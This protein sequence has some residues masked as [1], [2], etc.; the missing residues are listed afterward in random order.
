MSVKKIIKMSVRVITLANLT[1]NYYCSK[2]CRIWI[3]CSALLKATSS[4]PDWLIM[5]K[6]S[7]FCQGSCQLRIPWSIEYRKFWASFSGF[8]EGSLGIRRKLLVKK[9]YV[10]LKKERE[11][12]K[13]YRSQGAATMEVKVEYR[14]DPTELPGSGETTVSDVHPAARVFT[15]SWV[16]CS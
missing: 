15:G 11:T 9:I 1:T 13:R 6:F 7:H 12:G 2:S 16:E 10:E 4:G 5:Q 3:W 8:E 14:S